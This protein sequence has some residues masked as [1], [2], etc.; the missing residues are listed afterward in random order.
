[1]AVNLKHPKYYF[2]RELSWLKFND[3]VLEEAADNFHPLLERLKFLAIYSSNLD[4]FY[5]IRVGGL[6]EQIAA[7]IQDAPAD[8]LV[9]EVQADLVAEHVHKSIQWQYE[10]LE[11]DI[12]PKLKNKGIRIRKLNTLR[13]R[14][15]GYIEEYFNDQIFPVLTP[16]AIDPT[17]PFPKLKSLG[18]SLLLDLRAPY[19]TEKKKAVIH[20]PSTL[21]RFVQLPKEGNNLDFVAIEDIIQK[22]AGLLFHQMKILSIA[23]FRITRNADIDLAEAEADDLLKHIE[24]ELRKRRIGTV[25]R[26]EVS[27]EMSQEN[28]DFLQSMTG[29]EERGIFDI[30]SYLDL[31]SFFQFLGL[32]FPDL[33]DNPFTPVPSKRFLSKKD[34]FETIAEGDILLHHPYESFNHVSKFL[35]EASEDPQVLAIKITLYRTTGQSPIVA[36]LKRAVENGKQVTALIE[37]KARF[38]EENNIVWAK[39]LDTA[40]VNVVYGILGLKTHCKI[41]MVVRKEGKEVRR[42]LHLSTGNYN[43]KTARIYT[44]LGLMTANPDM[45]E[46]ASALFNLLTGY[47][48]QKEWK[49][50]MIAPSALRKNLRK[51]AEDCIQ[52]H[53]KANPSEITIVVNSL[54]DPEFIRLLYK[55][56]MIGIKVDLIVRGI[57]CLRP[58]VPGVSENIRVKSIVGRFLEHTRI[59]WFRYNGK[60]HIY[61]G[62]ADLMQ[63]NLDRRVEL[64]FP[65]EDIQIK[66]R[67]Q[68]IVKSMW[69]D[70]R[71]SRWLKQDG[72][73]EQVKAGKGFDVQH[74][75]ISEA[76][77]RQEGIDTIPIG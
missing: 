25:I 54:V 61:M 74:F 22:H 15:Q 36:A 71:N 75:L 17:H 46:D 31:T 14:E 53:R 55:A 10:L 18:L 3:R 67:V 50:F 13:K 41:T 73:Y 39:E 52:N 42:Y 63:R 6:M 77:S 49:K 9:P 51:L 19:K 44:D 12:L 76:L 60:S 64:V 26:M 30:P 45:G 37:L 32:N 69:E 58:G 34:V 59:F 72:T 29:I 47:S 38:D 4:E 2:N 21:P 7:G 27:Q 68:T 24:R 11:A 66:R 20:I 70:E 8:G 23:T 40:G 33:K 56:S 62:S 48:L 43:E 5:M 65:V 1:M 28:R 16:L 35:K 57:C